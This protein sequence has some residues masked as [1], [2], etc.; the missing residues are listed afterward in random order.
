MAGE[1]RGE[2]V[3][4]SRDD[5]ADREAMIRLRYHQTLARADDAYW[6]AVN[7]AERLRQTLV[8]E[9]AERRDR[10]LEEGR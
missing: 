4:V 3:A 5:R 1:T 6:V 8:D 10:E 7:T 2:E 9:A